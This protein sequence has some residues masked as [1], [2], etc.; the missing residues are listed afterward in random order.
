MI[1][2]KNILAE[3]MLRFGP[4]NLSESDRR[5]LQNLTE[6]YDVTLAKM[7]DYPSMYETFYK[8]LQKGVYTGKYIGTETI[9]YMNQNPSF[10]EESFISIYK[11]MIA[12]CGNKS[13]FL[14]FIVPTPGI[15]SSTLRL[16]TGATRQSSDVKKAPKYFYNGTDVNTTIVN[17]YNAENFKPMATSGAPKDDVDYWYETFANDGGTSADMLAFIQKNKA[18]LTGFDTIKTQTNYAT[19]VATFTNSVAKEMAASI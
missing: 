4:K 18:K 1:R 11:P 9:C 17:F 10:S 5:R 14:N 6:S 19:V 8:L 7:V 16:T 12:P 2:L 13:N 15:S 3:N